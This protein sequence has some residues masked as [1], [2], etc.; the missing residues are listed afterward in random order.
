MSRIPPGWEYLTSELGEN[1]AWDF[2]IEYK[3]AHERVR[4]DLFI[5]V[6]VV[7]ADRAFWVL[8][9]EEIRSEGLAA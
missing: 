5:R 2:A 8:R 9:R 6:R 1:D 3:R 4:S 7:K